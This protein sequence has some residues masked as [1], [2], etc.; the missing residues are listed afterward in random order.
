MAGGRPTKFN[1]DVAERLLNAIRLAAPMETACAIAG[2]HRDTLHDWSRRGAAHLE[3]AVLEYEKRDEKGTLKKDQQG[4]PWLLLRDARSRALA[5]FSDALK[6][7][8]AECEV[9]DLG[10]IEKAAGAGVWQAAAWRLERRYPERWG[11]RRVEL[12][13]ANGGPM[14]GRVVVTLPDNGRG[15]YRPDDDDE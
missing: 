3:T 1:A 7:A 14:E 4:Q 6:R 2:I 15:D 11:R 9:R 5:E 13:G 12:T 8:M 10:R